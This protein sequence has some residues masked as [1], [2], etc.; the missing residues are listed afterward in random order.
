MKEN[1]VMNVVC[2]DTTNGREDNGGGILF[3]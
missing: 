1:V 2:E 3:Y